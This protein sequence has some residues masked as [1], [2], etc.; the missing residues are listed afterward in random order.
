MMIQAIHQ[1]PDGTAAAIHSPR[2]ADGVVQRFVPGWRL[3][4]SATLPMTLGAGT[5]SSWDKS[6][7]VQPQFEMLAG[8]WRDETG[9]YSM[10][11]RKVS[12]PAYLRIVG[13]GR[14]AIPLILE[15]L[16]ER[17]GHWYQALEAILGYNP[18]HVPGPV[19]IR[20]LKEK[21]LDWGKQ[22]GYIS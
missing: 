15:E 9:M 13:M 6:I 14:Q 17:G 20:E 10:D 19:S 8:K 16:Q 3:A 22:Q 5:T 11:T 21:W 4:D 1:P 2:R 7:W 18:I 12:H